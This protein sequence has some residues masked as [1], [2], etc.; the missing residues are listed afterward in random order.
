MTAVA[1]L[2]DATVVF[3]TTDDNLGPADT[4]GVSDLYTV[5]LSSGDV[6]LLTTDSTGM[7]SAN[8]A[9]TSLVVSQ[10]RGTLAFRSAAS[11]LGPTD[12]NAVDDVYVLDLANGAIE[13]ASVD[14]AGNP[15]GAVAPG[16]GLSHDG[17][18][19]AFSSAA[20]GIV[21]TPTAGTQVYVR[22]L[23]TGT[24]TL[25]SA[26]S[27]GVTL[28][29]GSLVAGTMD[30]T[31]AQVAFIWRSTA[32]PVADQVYLRELGS[33]TTV[34]VSGNGGIPGNGRS[35]GPVFAPDGSRL[36]FTSSASNLV[37]ED[38]NGFSDVFVAYDRRGPRRS[39]LLRH[40]RRL[41]QPAL[42]HAE[43]LA[44]WLQAGVRQRRREHRPRLPRHLG[45]ALP[46]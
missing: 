36:A 45:R 30:S 32:N 22:D 21:P 19:V 24:T 2:D 37:T 8:G 5:D 1:F 39:R 41:R 35:S 40:E 3:A 14:L 7:A 46:P 44:R 9:T 18:K 12:E 38:T 31:G 13:V 6:R 42:Q 27:G 10:D 33:G 11:N 29:A 16:L 34:L 15:A 26:G 20:G 23:D 43:L 17:T 25:A 4:N 28:P